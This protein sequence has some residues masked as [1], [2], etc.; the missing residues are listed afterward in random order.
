MLIYERGKKLVG[1]FSGNVTDPADFI[2]EKKGD[3]VLFTIGD[4]VIEGNCATKINNDENLKEALLNSASGRVALVN[5]VSVVEQISVTRDCELDLNDR[6]LTFENSK[7]NAPITCDEGTLT[8]KGGT[9]DAT[10]KSSVVPICAWGGKLV[11]EDVTVLANSNTESCVF[12]N[13]G[14]VVIN[15]GK[16]INK[17]A[18]GYVYG[19]GAPLV[20]NVR[21]GSGGK[22]TCYGGFFVGRDPAL[23]DDADGGTFVADEYVSVPTT[24]DGYEG[25]EVRK[26]K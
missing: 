22:I 11:L 3:K 24:I 10:K 23:G 26:A 12:C 1:V 4:N 18:D 13:S 8:V 2:V 14:E 7:S 25:F 16:Y 20:L 5:D 15:S 17:S 19:E 9:L 21:N 6:T